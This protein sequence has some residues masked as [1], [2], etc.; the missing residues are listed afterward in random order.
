MSKRNSLDKYFAKRIENNEDN[1]LTKK[2]RIDNE[3]I[4]DQS[5]TVASQPDHFTVTTHQQVIFNPLTTTQLQ[6]R[7][8]PIILNSSI[9]ILN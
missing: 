1:T 2:R 3:N 4:I 5:N 6:G 8:S 7:H 9:I